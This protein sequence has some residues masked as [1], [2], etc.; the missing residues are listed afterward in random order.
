MKGKIGFMA[1]LLPKK[2]V[3]DPKPGQQPLSAPKKS[4]VDVYFPEDGR[5]LT[6]Y[7]DQFDLKVGSIVFVD[8]KLKGQPGCVRRLNYNFKIK[9][10]AYKN[11]ISLADTQVHGKLYIADSHYM[12]FDPQVLPKEKVSGWFFPPEEPYLTSVDDTSFSLDEL[13]NAPFSGEIIEKGNDYFVENRVIY[14][15]LSQGKGYAIVSGT[16]GYEVEFT[17]QDRI[18]SHMTCTCPCCFNC[19][20]QFAVL[21]Q[22]RNT[23]KTIEKDYEAEYEKS[24]YFAVMERNT[25][26]SYA[27]TTRDSGSIVL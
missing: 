27:L 16:H 1:D 26:N 20:H 12:T 18:I 23:L 21:L 19:K 14:L 5:T 7:N 2:K 3:P 22:L 25:L 4:L 11:V 9:P 10:D 15:T 8:G 24:G 13:L 6:Y 17:C